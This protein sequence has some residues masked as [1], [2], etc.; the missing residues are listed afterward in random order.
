MNGSGPGASI[1]SVALAELAA[2]VLAALAVLWAAGFF[3]T[4]SLGSYGY[5]DYKLNLLWPLL[6]YRGWSQI[7]PDWPHTKY[8]YEGLSFLGIGII[9]LL[10]LGLLTGVFT[11]LRS[12]VTRRWLPLAIMLALMTLFALSKDI[13]FANVRLLKLDL[14]GWIEEI[15]ATFR[16][17]GRFVWPL[18]YVV[19]IGAVVLIGGRLRARI[20]VPVALAAFAAQAVDSGPALLNF[21]HHLAP[22]SSTWSSPLQSPFWARAAAAG[23]DR[24]R[25]VPVQSPGTDWRPLGY[26]AVTHGMD[27]DSV[28]LGRTDEKKLALLR[29]HE[30]QVLSTGAFE[31][32][33]IYILDTAAALA[34][35]AHATADDL[36]GI[37]DHRIVFARGGAHL[38]AGLDIEPHLMPAN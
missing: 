16:S 35:G 11:R 27:I 3:I 9:A 15:A 18:L 13:H 6:T 8:D 2:G 23:Y 12:T 1:W 14:P 32:R 33:T 31:P 26:Y 20:A 38:V 30:M 22:V 25:V 34:A 29:G 21:A 19:T 10:C 36:L 37:V 28:Y 5:G 4:G 17:T 7:F 24:I